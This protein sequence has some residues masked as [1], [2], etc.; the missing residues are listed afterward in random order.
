MRGPIAYEHLAA[1]IVQTPGLD[2]SMQGADLDEVL[3]N[4]DEPI[5]KAQYGAMLTKR[6]N[7]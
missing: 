3:G 5:V 7:V 2:G 6:N 4:T 1:A